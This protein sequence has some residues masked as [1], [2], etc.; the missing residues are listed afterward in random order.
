MHRSTVGL[1]SAEQ[2]GKEF[3]VAKMP[4]LTLLIPHYA[5]TILCSSQDL[6]KKAITSSAGRFFLFEYLAL[7]F[8]D[9]L[10]NMV[11]AKLGCSD[12][13]VRR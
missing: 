10:E 11:P 7:Y 13:A 12:V 4:S 8:Q 2:T 5:E 1:V 3:A 6:W 9:E